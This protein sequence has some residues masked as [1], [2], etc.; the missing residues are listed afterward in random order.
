[1]RAYKSS[2]SGRLLGGEKHG[3]L[4]KQSVAARLTSFF[5]S[6]GFSRDEKSNQQPPS[7]HSVMPEPSAARTVSAT[8]GSS[9]ASPFVERSDR[10]KSDFTVLPQDEVSSRNV[11]LQADGWTNSQSQLK[12]A[13]KPGYLT[14]PRPGQPSRVQSRRAKELRTIGGDLMDGSPD[15]DFG[16]ITDISGDT[17]PIL[18]A[19]THLLDR[20]LSHSPESWKAMLPDHETVYPWSGQL[21]MYT[22][23]PLSNHLFFTRLL[24]HQTLPV[25]SSL[26]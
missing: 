21:D 8:M 23:G 7:K 25:H 20:L 6:I 16:L 10:I 12:H 2:N 1:M 26:T 19:V 22:W 5:P 4:Q 13:D 17:P 24:N 18:R 14:P 3:E 9:I 11:R 15:R